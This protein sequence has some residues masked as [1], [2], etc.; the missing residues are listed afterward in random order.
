MQTDIIQTT[1][2]I[3][4]TIA[5]V[6]SLIYVSIQIRDGSKSVKSQTYQSIISSYAEI[7]ARIGQDSETAKI[8]YLGCEHPEKLCSE[9]E[10]IRF[11]QL[12]CSIFNFFENLHYQYKTG[13]LD[14]HLWAGWCELMRSKL[15][16]PGV[17][18][19][20]E[21]NCYFYSKDFREYVMSGRC[22]KNI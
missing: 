19:Y 17:N 12:I 2:S 5:V 10:E 7:E 21:E 20:W 1:T 4:Q 22:P 15:K 16:K 18:Q 8:Y 13:L 11:T 14:E 9:E 6:I 3:I